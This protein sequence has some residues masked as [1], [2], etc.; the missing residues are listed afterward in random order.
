MFS[1]VFA[2]FKVHLTPVIKSEWKYFIGGEE[3][4]N[5]SQKLNLVN[6]YNI[7]K[8]C[9]R[10]NGRQ[11]IIT[12]SL[13]MHITHRDSK[14]K[15][16][17]M[18]T[19]TY[20]WDLGRQISLLWQT[21]NSCCFDPKASALLGLP[22]RICLDQWMSNSVTVTIPAKRTW[23]GKG[24]WMLLCL[25]SLPSKLSDEEVKLMLLSFLIT[26]G[27]SHWLLN[28]FQTLLR[29][30]NHSWSAGTWV[31]SQMELSQSHATHF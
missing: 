26:S 19:A 23:G 17:G 18:F 4:R 29:D 27:D 24:H 31:S 16:I 3:K 13:H 25:T 30:P 9:Q 20:V 6:C 8:R 11:R 12:K 22:S 10:I 7:R 21:T 15:E 2:S 28:S 5:I 14:L 1:G